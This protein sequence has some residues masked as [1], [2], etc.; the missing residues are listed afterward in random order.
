E[1]FQRSNNPG[2]ASYSGYFR[3][4]KSGFEEPLSTHA[5]HYQLN[6][7]YSAASYSKGAVF[8]SQLGYVIGEEARDRG[9]LRYFDTWKFRHP[10]ANDLIRVMEKESGMELDW[11]KEYFVY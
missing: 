1:I 5:D 6:S 10:N 11:Y 8:L 2:R 9:M 4:V 7:A 3:L